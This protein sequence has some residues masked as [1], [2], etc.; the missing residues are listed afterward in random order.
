MNQYSDQPYYDG[1]WLRTNK[2]N[3]YSYQPCY[4]YLLKT[5]DGQNNPQPKNYGYEEDS[6][7]DEDDH[8]PNY[9]L[10]QNNPQ[11][12]DYGNEKNLIIIKILMSQLTMATRKIMMAVRK[13]MIMTRIIMSQTMALIVKTLLM[14]MWNH[15][16]VLI[17]LTMKWFSQV[18]AMQQI[19][20]L[21]SL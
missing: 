4:G 13:I 20:Q 9:G 11:P 17:H 2:N 21:T 8:E 10:D 19:Q 15:L 5:D 7:Y 6:D 12:N 18:M 3:Q 14:D 16:R 1:Y